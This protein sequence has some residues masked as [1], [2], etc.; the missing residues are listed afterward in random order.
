MACVLPK[1]LLLTIFSYTES[2]IAKETLSETLKWAMDRLVEIETCHGTLPGEADIDCL[3]VCQSPE[4][5]IYDRFDRFEFWNDPWGPVF[6]TWEPS[7]K[8]KLSHKEAF[9][10]DLTIEWED[11][12]DPTISSVYR[13]CYRFLEGENPFV[14]FDLLMTAP[15]CT[16]ECKDAL[17][18]FYAFNIGGDLCDQIELDELEQDCG[19]VICKAQY[20]IYRGKELTEFVLPLEQTLQP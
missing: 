17:L 20:M 9:H 4:V 5:Q 6:G 13:K 7:I 12:N 10:C 16:S 8:F 19:L 11:W 1:D 14:D 3:F 15:R 18:A 2:K